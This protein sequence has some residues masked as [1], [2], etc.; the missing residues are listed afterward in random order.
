MSVRSPIVLQNSI[1]LG[2]GL[3]LIVKFGCGV[4][5]S[6]SRRSVLIALLDMT[7]T[8]DKGLQTMAVDGRA[9]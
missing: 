1:V 3:D 6:M 8:P 9:A 7:P 4:A 2:G 5:H